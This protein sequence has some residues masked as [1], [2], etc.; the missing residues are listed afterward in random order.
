MRT[1]RVF[2]C[3]R[4]VLWGSQP[5]TLTP[6][7]LIRHPMSS[8]KTRQ[9][10]F[11]GVGISKTRDLFE[12]IRSIPRFVFQSFL[13]A[14]VVNLR[15]VHNGCLGGDPSPQL[16]PAWGPEGSRQA[17]RVWWE[18][19]QCHVR[20]T[21]MGDSSSSRPEDGTVG[22]ASASIAESFCRQKSCAFAP[23]KRASLWS[24]EVSICRWFQCQT[25]FLVVW[26][27]LL[28]AIHFCRRH[29][30]PTA[31]NRLHSLLCCKVLFLRHSVSLCGKCSWADFELLHLGGTR[32]VPLRV[33]GPML[34]PGGWRAHYHQVTTSSNVDGKSQRR[35][36][37][38]HCAGSSA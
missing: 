15:S 7:C 18:L 30:K 5:P 32:L 34:G 37:G 8:G 25:T 4:F 24:L 23:G 2:S 38:K 10:V 36:E 16:A 33:H 31:G 21:S 22:C 9:M 17:L 12:D 26:L 14:F 3:C 1:G 11:Q 13:G 19:G 27:L 6:R 35:L 20:V 29:L 28:S